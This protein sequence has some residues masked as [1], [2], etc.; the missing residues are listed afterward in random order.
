MR[1]DA[2]KITAYSNK[3][4]LYAFRKTENTKTTF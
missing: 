3:K 4:I 2:H 1:I